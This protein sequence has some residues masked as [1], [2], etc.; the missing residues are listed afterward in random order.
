MDEIDNFDNKV[1][2]V[3]IL[4]NDLIELIETSDERVANYCEFLRNEV[5]ICTESQIMLLQNYREQIFDDI[6]RYEEKCIE[7]KKCK[8][9][10][11]YLGP[12]N[13]IKNE[14]LKLKEDKTVETIRKLNSLE[15][16]LKE[17]KKAL[18]NL[19]YR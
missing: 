10:K 5:D 17:K 13:E 9:I 18:N 8:E 4:A 11:E 19:I 16:N 14:C 7:F 1:N 3:E 2:K 15:A 6:S 12:I